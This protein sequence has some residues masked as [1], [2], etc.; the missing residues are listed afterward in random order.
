[1]QSWVHYHKF[2]P[3]NGKTLLCDLIHYELPGGWLSEL[4]LGWWVNSRLKAMF[5]Y[6]HQVTQKECEKMKY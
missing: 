1:M 2:T 5:E 6:R 4:L 3:K